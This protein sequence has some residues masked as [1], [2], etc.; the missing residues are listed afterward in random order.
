MSNFLTIDEYEVVIDRLTHQLAQANIIIAEQKETIRTCDELSRL[1]R[2]KRDQQS[3]LID[4]LTDS[5]G[6]S[7]FANPCDTGRQMKAHYAAI[8]ILAELAAFRSK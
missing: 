2:I 6:E 5:L 8:E 4:K 1:T 3:V 7:D